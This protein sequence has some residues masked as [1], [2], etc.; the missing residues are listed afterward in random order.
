MALLLN[1]C[2]LIKYVV[3]SVKVKEPKCFVCSLYSFSSL[4]GQLKEFGSFKEDLSVNILKVATE[5][6]TFNFFH[7][8]TYIQ[9]KQIIEK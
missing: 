6:V 3:C 1:C 9:E 4:L 7:I 5:V 2:D 8:V